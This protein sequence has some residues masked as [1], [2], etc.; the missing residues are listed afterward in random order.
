MVSRFPLPL[1]HLIA[2]SSAISFRLP[3]TSI[4]ADASIGSPLTFRFPSF[5]LFRFC[6]SLGR[7]FR[8]VSSASLPLSDPRCFRFLSVASVLGSD[9][10]ASAL[11][12]S[13]LHASASQLLPRCSF[14]PFV[15]PVFPLLSRL[16]SHPFL[17]DPLTQ[18]RCM[19]PFALPRFATTA[20][21][22]V[23]AFFPV[24][25]VPLLPAS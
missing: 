4:S 24:S 25:F 20:V 10:S 9:Y 14:G 1:T 7:P 11:P 18:L 5:P 23:L 3:P 19:F 12:F 22:R 17:P 15:P 21:P 6:L 8:F 13:S 16:V 2:V